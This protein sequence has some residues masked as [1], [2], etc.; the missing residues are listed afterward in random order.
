MVQFRTELVDQPRSIRVEIMNVYPV[1][2]R[3]ALCSIA[4]HLPEFYNRIAGIQVT[5]THFVSGRNLRTS[6]NIRVVNCS[7]NSF[8]YRPSGNGN[9]VSG[10]KDKEQ[11]VW[12]RL[13]FTFSLDDVERTWQLPIRQTPLPSATFRDH[14][15]VQTL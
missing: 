14:R 5:Q 1:A 6:N 9:G 12:L 15:E 3:N 11:I 8:R 7:V 4:N 13:Q 10:M 2:L